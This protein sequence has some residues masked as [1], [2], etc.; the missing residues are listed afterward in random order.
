MTETAAQLAAKRSMDAVRNKDREAWLSNFAEDACV[1]DPVG[2]SPL[3][4]TGSGHT[5]QEAIG[6][7]WDMMIAPGVIEFDIRES[8]PAGDTAVANVGSIFNTMPDGSKIEARGVFVY[9]VNEE[10]KVVNLR[11][12]WDYDS[13][14]QGAGS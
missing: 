4:P 6:N 8:W 10:G 3:D 1:E 11:A 14:V 9:H 5:G 13:T 12:Y 7:F 2:I